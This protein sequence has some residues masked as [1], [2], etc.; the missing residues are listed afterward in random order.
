LGEEKFALGATIKLGRGLNNT[1][2]KMKNIG[3]NKK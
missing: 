2:T 3:G 1:N